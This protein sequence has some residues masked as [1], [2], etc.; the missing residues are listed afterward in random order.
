ME[1]PPKGLNRYDFKTYIE[2]FV[3]QRYYEDSATQHLR[4]K[5]CHSLLQPAVCIVEITTSES[6]LNF[7]HIHTESTRLLMLPYCPHCEGKPQ[8]TSTTIEL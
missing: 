7:I 6:L 8:N 2:T 4:C 5:K 3:N 1:A